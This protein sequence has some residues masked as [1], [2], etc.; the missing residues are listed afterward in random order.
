MTG[1]SCSYPD[2][3][4]SEAWC[5]EQLE[6]KRRKAGME[7]V[8]SACL[9]RTRYEKDWSEATLICCDFLY[10]SPYCAAIDGRLDT[11]DECEIQD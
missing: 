3:E 6:P 1:Y 9:V 2:R 5:R 11:W 8:G 7:D 10:E 4:D